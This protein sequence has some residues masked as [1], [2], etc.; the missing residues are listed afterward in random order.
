M[1]QESCTDPS[2]SLVVY[3]T[4]EVD[5]IQLAMSGEDPSCIP[6]FP[7]GFAIVPVEPTAAATSDGSSSEAAA[8]AGAKPS[9]LLTVGLHV[10][11][12]TIPSAK[13][14]LPSVTA[15]NNHLSN[16][17][18]Q[19]VAALGSTTAAT[20]AT[21]TNCT[22]ENGSTSLDHQEGNNKHDF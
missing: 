10:L 8:A 11:V 15:L 18:Q 21:T 22:T 1:L 9:C 13:L 6:I 20:A 16:T 3:S 5:A 12:S 14:S 2:G 17:V 7:I 19:I 4:M